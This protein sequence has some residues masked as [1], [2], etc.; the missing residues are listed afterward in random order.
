MLVVAVAPETSLAL[1]VT[2][3][4]R[5]RASASIRRSGGDSEKY[6]RLP[7]LPRYSRPLWAIRLPP[8]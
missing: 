1:T 4:R 8:T 6:R 5:P 2:G 7:L 3:S